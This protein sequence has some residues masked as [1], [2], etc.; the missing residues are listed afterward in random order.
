M[1][2]RTFNHLPSDVADKIVD[3]VPS[4]NNIENIF[5]ALRWSKEFSRTGAILATILEAYLS[6]NQIT[7]NEYNLRWLLEI[8]CLIS[9]LDISEHYHSKN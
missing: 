1:S 5:V 9:S 2:W 7:L 8:N 4:I 3:F 6:R